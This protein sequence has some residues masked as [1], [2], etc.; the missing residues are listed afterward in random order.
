MDKDLK[1]P[2]SVCFWTDDPMP[3]LLAGLRDGSVKIFSLEEGNLV[4]LLCYLFRPCIF[5]QSIQW[6]FK[7]HN[8]YTHLH[9]LFF[10]R[11]LSATGTHWFEN[12]WHVN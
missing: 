12:A 1:I 9:S 6:N 4:R 10:P 5:S 8:G 3:Y 2:E 11:P 7:F